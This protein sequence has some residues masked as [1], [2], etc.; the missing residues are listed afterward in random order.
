M[1]ILF[2]RLKPNA[3]RGSKPR[4]HLLTHGAQDAVA[5]RLTALAAPFASV[6]PT[7]FWMPEGFADCNE[8]TLPEA[9]R[10]LP[11]EIRY[12]LKRWWLALPNSNSQTPNWDIV[13]TCTIEGKSG[14][15]LIEAKAHD[16]E[17]IKEEGGKKFKEASASP[18]SRRNHVQIG[19]V[20]CAA[21]G[22]LA[23]DTGVRWA[24]S[25]DS[26]YQM[27]NRFA[28]AWKLSNLGIPVVLVYLGFLNANEMRDQ[29]SPLIDAADWQKIV[30]HHSE[31]LFPAEVWDRSWT[32]AGQP[33]IPLIRAIDVPLSDRNLA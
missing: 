1:S 23:E 15:L 9:E 22:A 17:L 8:A 33:F 2:E 26:K 30:K 4:C 6:A 11:P 16:E 28:W 21:S 14:I 3:Q 20:I 12:E 32:C 19:E 13:S 5:K 24:L 27:S 29:G 25:R 31:T 10:L 7:D 18:N